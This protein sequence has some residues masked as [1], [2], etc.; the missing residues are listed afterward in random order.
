MPTP[1]NRADLQRV[2]GMVNYTAKFVKDHSKIT[3]PLR[4]LLHKDSEWCWEPYH[5]QAFDTLKEMLASPPV[6]RYFYVSKPVTLTCDASQSG[7]GAA[8]LQDG[9]PVAYA[10]RAFTPAET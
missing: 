2:L 4:D 3:T 9:Q 7:I 5:Q 6:L 1:K 8:C 10:S